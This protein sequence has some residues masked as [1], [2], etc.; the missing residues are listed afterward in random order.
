MEDSVLY[1]RCKEGE[2]KYKS[3]NK[4]KIEKRELGNQEILVSE[5][6]KIK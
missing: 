1:E 3:V 2:K 4:P 6:H 5:K